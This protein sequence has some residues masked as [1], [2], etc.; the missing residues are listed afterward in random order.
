MM[1]K[2]LAGKTVVVS[3]T[4]KGI[5][6]QMVET[7]AANGA[8]VFALAR[9]ETDE[10]LA[11]CQKMA[12]SH[13]VKVIPVYF[14]LTDAEAMKDGIKKIR[15]EKLD[16]DGLVNNAGTTLT[17]LFQMTGMDDL[18]RVFE[19]NYFGTFLLTQYISKLMVRN[20]KGSIVTV[21]STAALD[22]NSGKAAYGSSKAALISLTKTI[23]EELG[24][25]GIRANIICPGVVKTPMLD[26]NMH[27]YILNA[28]IEASALKEIGQPSDIANTAMFLLSDHSSYISGQVIRVDAGVTRRNKGI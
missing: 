7:F 17:A 12:E 23:S 5:G 15:N 18:R 27:E 22:G 9:N 2:M 10:H 25:S 26:A 4:A 1:E 14:D 20:K 19:T 8:N 28:E 11:Y 21:A 3:G 13:G 16:I 24:N 6:Y